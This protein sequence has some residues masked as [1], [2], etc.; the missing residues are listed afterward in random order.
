MPQ[1]GHAAGSTTG[2]HCGTVEA[3]NQ[4]VVYPPT[5]VQGVPV[6]KPP[7]GLLS[8]MDMEKGELKWQT[9]HGDTPDVVR[10]SP[11]LRGMSIP[12]TGQAQTS[13]VGLVIT[14]TLVVM[15][16]PITTTLPDRPRG[17]MLRAYDKITGQQVGAVWMPAP[18]SG[19]PTT[20]AGVNCSYDARNQLTAYGSVLA[21]GN[22]ADGRRAWK[23]SASAPSTFSGTAFPKET[24]GGSRT[25]CVPPKFHSGVTC[26][27]GSAVRRTYSSS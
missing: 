9:P 16:D 3:K 21:A 5:V 15:G 25:C 12:K 20:Y 4:T 14:K 6:T 24:P 7:Y 17:A 26:G 27:G 19:N 23:Q 11:A 10:N 8:A 1:D 22:R 18:Q 2:T 13:G